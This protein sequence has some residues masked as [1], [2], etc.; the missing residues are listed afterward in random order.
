MWS[1]CLF[2]FGAMVKIVEGGS[3]VAQEQ[4][5]DKIEFGFQL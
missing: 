3:V 2:H 1:D 4:H 5:Q